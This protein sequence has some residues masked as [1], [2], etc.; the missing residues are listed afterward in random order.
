VRGIER[1]CANGQVLLRIV[2]VP[3]KLAGLFIPLTSLPRSASDAIPGGFCCHGGLS[4]VG[5]PYSDKW[6]ADAKV[7]PQTLQTHVWSIY[8]ADCAGLFPRVPRC[9]AQSRDTVAAER[10]PTVRPN[11]R[12][13]VKASRQKG[14]ASIRLG[15]SVASALGPMRRPS[16]PLPAIPGQIPAAPGTR[17]QSHTRRQLRVC[18]AGFVQLRL[19]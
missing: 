4:S 9:E 18:A 8:K 3:V 7:R 2:A 15:G 13:P 11:A 1:L 19:G 6:A 10:V 5:L 16:H 12:R 14:A 17:L